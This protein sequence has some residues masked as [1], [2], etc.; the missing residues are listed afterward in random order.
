MTA[1][2]HLDKYLNI[3]LPA[4]ILLFHAAMVLSLLECIMLVMFTFL[5]RIDIRVPLCLSGGIIL[6]LAAMYAESRTDKL[7]WISV[8]Y[9]ISMHLFLVPLASCYVPYA[10]YDFPVYF[11][12]GIAFTAILLK[13]RWAVLFITLNMVIDIICIRHMLE[14]SLVSEFVSEVGLESNRNIQYDFVLF[15]RIMVALL[16]TG[17]VCG[18][19]ISYRN[20]ILRR[21]IEKSTAME[22]E[23]EQL[24]YAKNMFLVNVSHEIR[25]PLNAILGISE[26]LLD[27][28]TDDRI[29]ENAFHIANSSKALLSITNELM[30]FS[31]LDDSDLDVENK[32]YSIG[33]I[34][35]ELINVLS[36]RYADHGT[37][38][39]VE[40]EPDIPA[41]LCG[42][43]TIIRQIMLNIPNGIMKSLEGGNIRL[44]IRKEECGEGQIRLIVEVC[45]EGAFQYSYK[46]QLYRSSVKETENDEAQPL[47]HRLIRLMGGELCME[48]EPLKRRYYFDFLQRY[49]PGKALVERPSQERLKV[50][51]YENTSM[52]GSV[53]AKALHEMN[54]DFC[55]AST[56]EFFLE[57]CVNQKY[58]HLMIASERYNDIKNK[59]VERLSPQSVILIGSDLIAYDDPLVKTTFARPVN[60]LNLDALLRDRQNSTIR[61][62]GYKGEFICPDARIM[63]VDDNIVNLEVATSLL[64]RYQAQVLLAASGKECLKLLQKENVD[65]I[66]LDYMM[67]EMDG[68]DTLRNIKALEV[69]GLS[70]VPIAALTANA[71]SGAREMFLEAGFDEYL[72]KPIERDKFEKI[73]REYLPKEKIIYTAGKGEEAESY[74]RKAESYIK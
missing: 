29:K 49:I 63:V 68:I 69:S 4:E 59:M 53:F 22:Q 43:E 39:Y 16:I 74:E 13:K 50:L 6:T 8:G 32:P 27:L 57:E 73:L 44:S 56:D 60:C 3:E 37:D 42:D 48:E 19:L 31:K 14:R 54:V 71:V 17:T 58:T 72:S 64:K 10:V 20:K 21:E 41:Q 66:F 45:A 28:D 1:K 2:Q 65:L 61:R 36:V 62:I 15:G 9:L 67:P 40:I 24:S 7:N 11:L 33:D 70:T 55:Q 35:D 38:L 25:T 18:I 46:E 5:L 47:M 51:F 30:D 34:C 12:T 52:Q 26:L 23:A